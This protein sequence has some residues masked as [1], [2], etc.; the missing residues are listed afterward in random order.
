VAW[1]LSSE[2]GLFHAV[3]VHGSFVSP[4]TVCPGQTLLKTEE[5]FRR[6]PQRV[7]DSLYHVETEQVFV[8]LNLQPKK[9][10]MI[11]THLHPPRLPPPPPPLPQE[12]QV[13]PRLATNE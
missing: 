6:A 5:I 11:T 9:K 7:Y 10:M 2:N 1:A 3:A 8:P 4:T 12:Q 13:H